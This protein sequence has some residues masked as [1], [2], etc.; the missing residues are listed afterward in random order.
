M[1]GKGR[2]RREKNYKAAHG[3]DDR[4]PPPPN[5]SSVDAVPSK[6][7]KLMSFA[8]AT[9]Q[10]DNRLKRDATHGDDK[11]TI[12][13]EASYSVGEAKGKKGDQGLTSNTKHSDGFSR[14]NI[15]GLTS[16]MKHGD[17][18]SKNSNL[19]KKKKKKRKNKAEDLR[20]ETVGEPGGA[21]TQRKER[22]KQRLEERK[23]KRK[24]PRIED[25]EDFHDHEHIKFG[26]VVQAPPKLTAV[27]KVFKMTHDASQER[28]RL[29][30]VEA[31]RKRKGW[32]S[33]PGVQLPPPVTMEPLL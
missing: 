12:S 19:E 4:L 11:G 30:A 8:G 14:N 32:V 2:K 5:P 17:G 28:L 21:G 26:E 25:D 13:G 24:R 27:P 29:Q 16:N 6:L 3:G 15:Q 18:V 7:R 1:G 9:K 31:Y 33:R 20:F 10:G 23:K 22:K